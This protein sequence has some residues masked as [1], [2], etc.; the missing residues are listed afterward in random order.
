MIRGTTP[1]I[2]MTLPEE[3]P[4]DEVTAAVFSIAQARIS[5]RKYKSR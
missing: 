4:V 3:I 2:T 1:T 5:S